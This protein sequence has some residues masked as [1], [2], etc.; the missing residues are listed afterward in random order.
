[1]EQ[2]QFNTSNGVKVVELLKN[3]TVPLLIIMENLI[4]AFS[5]KCL[6]WVNA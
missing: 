3:S 6:N 4:H 5:V 2:I 1:M